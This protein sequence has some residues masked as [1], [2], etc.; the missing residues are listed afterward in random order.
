MASPE[1]NA[2]LRARLE[3]LTTEY[4][5]VRSNL[6]TRQEQVR[7]VR[8]SAYA[9]ENG[10][11]VTVGPRGNL[12][13]LE[14]EPRAYRRLSPSQ[15]AEEILRLTREAADE[16]GA[17]VARIMAPFLPKGVAYQDI[18]EGNAGTEALT[19]DKPLTDDTFDAWWARIGQ[20]P[21]G[22]EDGEEPEAKR[23]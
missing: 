21:A 5:R 4:E 7:Q 17:R 2:V 12:T 16:A 10:V 6:T 23:R 14:I 13:E 9:P 22:I 3:Q 19:P 8:A 15:L 1:G 11:H 18:V 20:D